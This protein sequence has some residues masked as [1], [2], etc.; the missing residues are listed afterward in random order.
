LD[1]TTITEKRPQLACERLVLTHMGDEVL[2]R[3][4]GLDIEAAADGAAIEI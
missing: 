2:A 4:D 1:Y 3:L